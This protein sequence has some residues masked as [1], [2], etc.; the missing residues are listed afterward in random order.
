MGQHY[1]GFI[2]TSKKEVAKTR[3]T[4]I[5]LS[6]EKYIAGIKK[7]KLREEARIVYDELIKHMSKRKMR[8]MLLGCIM[9]PSY[10][11]R[12]AILYLI[13]DRKEREKNNER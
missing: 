9:Q 7:K 3:R 13:Y 5:D 1:D 6:I 10:K 8:V 4:T 11:L 2:N 12:D